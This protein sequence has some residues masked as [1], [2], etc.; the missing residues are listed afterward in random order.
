MTDWSERREGGSRFFLWLYIRLCVRVGRR[1]AHAC[2]YP[3]TFYFF[4]RRGA[5]RRA[6]RAFLTRVFGR[7][8]RVREILHHIHIYSSTILD[9]V[10]LLAKDTDDF[11]IRTH[12]LD[13]LDLQMAHGR[14]VLMLGAHIGS[15]EI[16]RTLAQERP[17]VCVRVV[18]DRRQTPALTE[19]LHAL[20]PDIAANVIDAGTD[21][22]ALALR[23]QEAAQ[24]GMLIGLLGDRRRPGQASE[25]VEFFGQPA[26]FP[27]A[28]YQLAAVL[29]LPVVLSF[30][31]YR[32]G[33]RYDL[34]FETFSE[35]IK[36][37]RDAR[38]AH[39]RE[40]AQRFAQRLEYYTRIDPFNWFNLYD[41]W[42]D[43]P[44]RHCDVQRDTGI[45]AGHST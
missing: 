44:A 45:A 26:P 38:A 39:L 20:N 34:Y 6:S 23:I 33:N 31:L 13:A 14:G 36:L 7:P 30:G 2:L 27:V 8:A 42:H 22:A 9:R 4:L 18:M 25:S 35:S 15:F 12:G 29:D 5:E 11:E 32:G 16:L 19:F 10:F 28:P 40:Y 1:F 3:I 17:D 41:F 37:P 43:D 21:P 24:Q